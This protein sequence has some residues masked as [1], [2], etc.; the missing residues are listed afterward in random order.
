MGFLVWL[1][2]TDAKNRSSDISQKQAAL[3]KLLEAIEMSDELKAEAT[4]IENSFAELQKSFPSR[5]GLSDY[6]ALL[7]NRAQAEKLGFLRVEP[8]DFSLEG[9]SAEALAK[10]EDSLPL[11]LEL[12]GSYKGIQNFLLEVAAEFPAIRLDRVEL[13]R[14]AVGGYTT[15]VSGLLFLRK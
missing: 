10:A 3:E 13:N 2:V 4:G 6:F 9:L 1:A 12:S 14:R 8:K 15:A 11:S 5:Q 7:E